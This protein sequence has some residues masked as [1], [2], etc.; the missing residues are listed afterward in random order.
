M[1]EDNY[2]RINKII[3][4][5]LENMFSSIRLRILS[6]YKNNPFMKATLWKK[7]IYIYT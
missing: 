2:K 4:D 7:L 3:N 1:D 5:S 6:A